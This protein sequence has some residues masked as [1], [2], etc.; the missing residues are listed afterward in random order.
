MRI[1]WINRWILSWL[2]S[3][4]FPAKKSPKKPSTS[5]SKPHPK[6]T[7]P[8][9]QTLISFN[10]TPY[11]ALI[12]RAIEISLSFLT[13][14]TV[15]Q[16]NQLF[17]KNVRSVISWKMRH[18]NEFFLM[19]YKLIVERENFEEFWIKALGMWLQNSGRN[20]CSQNWKCETRISGNKRTSRQAIILHNICELRI[21][22]PPRYSKRP[23]QLSQLS[24]VSIRYQL[25]EIYSNKVNINNSCHFNWAQMVI[26]K[27]WSCF[28][29][30]LFRV[31][32]AVGR[33]IE[34]VLIDYIN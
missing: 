22:I 15:E 19:W 9:Q 21:N 11:S 31:D 30:D 27:I 26:I 5:K 8:S 2:Y 24:I 32:C 12:L 3:T 13:C 16:S 10:R 4:N 25:L 14:D 23:S 20:L 18:R 6:A 7:F 33:L 29:L 34:V 1:A 17:R 28:R